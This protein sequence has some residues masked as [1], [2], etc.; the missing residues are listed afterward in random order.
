[1]K[2]LSI[3][4][5]WASAIICLGKDIENRTWRTKF[6]GRVLIHAG[7]TFDHP[8]WERLIRLHPTMESLLI[9]SPIL[10]PRGG[11][12]GSV[13]IVD[14]TNENIKSKWWEGPP[15]YGWRLKDPESCQFIPCNGKLSF[16]D[17]RV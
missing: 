12:I 5:P 15:V 2:A 8:G 16:F 17:V 14:C 1:M 11:I 4:Q 9:S 13:E 7:K 3:R 6:R 10:A